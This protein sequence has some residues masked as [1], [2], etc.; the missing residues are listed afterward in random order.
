MSERITAPEFYA[1]DGV[2]DW[3]LLYGGN[4]PCVHYRTG[5]FAAGVA[6]VQAIGD[7]ATATH[8][9]PDVDLR[10][11]GVSVRLARLPGE[12]G[13]TASDVALARRISDAA[14]ALGLTADPARVQEVQIAIDVLD[15][16]AVRPFWSAV[17]GY[18]EVGDEDLLDDLRRG[19]TIWFQEMDEPRPQRNRIHVDLYVPHDQAG[20]RVAGGLAAGGRMV[21][22]RYAPHYWTLADPE[23]NEVDVAPWDQPW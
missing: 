12:G 22:D 5:S 19:P 8:R 13:V 14:R 1:S 17:L 4:W 7:L 16:A 20:A 11:D 15:I 2:A 9:H 6:L 18:P 10:A 3:R 23:G 21:N